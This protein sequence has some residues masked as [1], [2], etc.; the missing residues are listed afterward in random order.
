LN[1]VSAE[2]HVERRLEL[3]AERDGVHRVP[4]ADVANRMSG[5]RLAGAFR[6]TAMSAAVRR[7][8]ALSL[9]SG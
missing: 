4:A 6:K 5:V 8:R 2:R 7:F 9:R 1:V 3:E